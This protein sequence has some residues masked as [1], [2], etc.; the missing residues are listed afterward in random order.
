MEQKQSKCDR[1]REQSG[2]TCFSSLATMTPPQHI[3][4]CLETCTTLRSLPETLQTT[5][6]QSSL[7]YLVPSTYK[8]HVV[9]MDIYLHTSRYSFAQ[10]KTLC[11]HI[12]SYLFQYCHLILVGCCNACSAVGIP[13][14]KILFAG[15]LGLYCGNS[16]TLSVLELSQQHKPVLLT[17]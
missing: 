6:L 17:V 5:A 4:F 7:L 10:G 8:L 14:P 9:T 2:K 11:L 12:P 16:R 15:H 1:T 3:S 13:V